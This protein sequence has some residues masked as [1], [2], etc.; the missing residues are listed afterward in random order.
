MCINARE[1]TSLCVCLCLRER[2]FIWLCACLHRRNSNSNNNNERKEMK[3]KMPK[4][5]YILM[6]IL[7][8][9]QIMA[10]KSRRRRR[11]KKQG[12]KTVSY[13]KKTARK[14]K[15]LKIEKWNWNSN[16]NSTNESKMK[17]N[18]MNTTTTTL[19]MIYYCVIS[20]VFSF[21]LN[22]LSIVLLALPPIHLH[23]HINNSVLHYRFLL[24]IFTMHSLTQT[25][26]QPNTEMHALYINKAFYM[27]KIRETL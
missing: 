23:S 9:Q 15:N 11:K 20:F 6:W 12:N 4:K 27:K 2:V 13:D 7:I 5:R 14:H 10:A 24:I 25:H 21:F 19:E 22:H 18:E 16:R 3:K 17:W 26:T 8:R 1:S